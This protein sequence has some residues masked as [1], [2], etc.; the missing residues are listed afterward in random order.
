MRL[1]RARH[2]AAAALGPRHDWHA[3]HIEGA[4]LPPSPRSHAECGVW[5][6]GAS[7]FAKAVLTA[8][9]AQRDVHLVDSFQGLP[10]NTTA[11]DQQ[12]AGRRAAN[13][14]RNGA[15]RNGLSACLWMP[16][17][18][19]PF[20]THARPTGRRPL[21]PPA[22]PSVQWWGEMDYLRV[23]QPEV[24]SGFVRFGLLDNSVHFHKASTAVQWLPQRSLA[25]G[26]S[27]VAE[28]AA[29]APCVIA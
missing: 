8:H 24:Q 7:L 9:G 23:S 22:N 14:G 29:V 18:L 6:G 28:G 27:G 15:A 19:L 16:A 2:P 13:S 12:V 21:C 11:Q 3:A 26:A 10:P 5:R 20:C 4:F 17:L 1:C 25:A